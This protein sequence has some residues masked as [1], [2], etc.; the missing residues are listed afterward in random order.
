MSKKKFP[1]G[2]KNLKIGIL[3]MTEGNVSL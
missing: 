1:L 3:G 2:D